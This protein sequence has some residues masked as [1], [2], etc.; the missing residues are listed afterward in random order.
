MSHF[1]IVFRSRPRQ[2]ICTV[3][4]QPASPR[5]SCLILDSLTGGYSLVSGVDPVWR[6]ATKYVGA[7]GQPSAQP[8]SVDAP[9]T[10]VYSETALVKATGRH[11]HR[12]ARP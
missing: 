6:I 1:L 8:P 2:N 12:L 4:Q 9:C 7:L 5:Y 3:L 10:E 11:P